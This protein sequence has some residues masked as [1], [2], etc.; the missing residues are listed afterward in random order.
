MDLEGPSAIA[1]PEHV[2]AT[3]RLRGSGNPT[4]STRGEGT[5][6]GA[7]RFGSMLVQAEFA[8]ELIDEVTKAVQRV[9]ELVSQLHATLSEHGSD[10]LGSLS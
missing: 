2:A 5:V 8:D 3:G 10:V 9:L 1:E 4:T 7:F 6:T